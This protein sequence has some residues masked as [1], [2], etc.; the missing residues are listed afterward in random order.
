M[1]PK[2]ASLLFL[3]LSYLKNLKYLRKDGLQRISNLVPIVE[4]QDLPAQ[5]YK[6]AVQEP[7]DDPDLEHHVE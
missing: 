3:L 6:L 7:V 2:V 4:T 1:P 5:A